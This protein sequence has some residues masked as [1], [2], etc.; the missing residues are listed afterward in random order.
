MVKETKM[1]KIIKVIYDHW[2]IVLSAILTTPG[3][4]FYLLPKFRKEIWSIVIKWLFSSLT[5]W[6]LFLILLTVIVCVFF[7]KKY[8]SGKNKGPSI[9]F[10]TT[11]PTYRNKDLGKYEYFDV[12][13]KFWLGS[14]TVL[15]GIIDGQD[16]FRIWADGPYCPKC[17]YELDKNFDKKV[18]ECIRCNKKYKIPK[19]ILSHTREKVIKLFESDM[20]NNE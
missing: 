16:D 13:W 15:P 5:G 17:N 8:F 11:R 12:N 4:I 7:Y 10:I 2:K 9:A 1:K 3:V 6:I 14:D 20:K 18:W 19:K